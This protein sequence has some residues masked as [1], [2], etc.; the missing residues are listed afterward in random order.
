MHQSVDPKAGYKK[1]L[2]YV[3]MLVLAYIFVFPLL[4]MISSSFKPEN[5]I[6]TDLY[7]INAV[8][9]VGHIS[10]DNYAAVFEKS[11]IGKF[12]FNSIFITGSS[13]IL[14]LLINSMAAFSLSRLEWRGKTLVLSFIISLLIIPG[15]AI[16][17]PLLNLVAHLP[18]LGFDNNGLVIEHSWLNSFQV[19]IIPGLANAFSIFLFYQ[20]FKDIPKD[21]DEAAAI[22]GA[23]PFQIYW[24]IIVPMS[25]P[26]F[27][28]VAILQFLGNWNAY[29]WP[30][31]VTQSEDVRP[32]MLGIQ[33]FFGTSTSWGEVMAYATLITLPV[34]VIFLIFQRKFV[35]SLAGSGIKG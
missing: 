32:V 6:F 11:R 17:I 15:E 30:V 24:R 18:W 8:L 22:D 29:L 4:F 12:F 26:V 5:Q 10:F 9:P 16:M 23:K 3:V 31:L 28:T 19:Q 2:T 25:G 34:L 7:S 21:F 33:Q 27:A 14:G 20:F 13:V 35:Q 1:M